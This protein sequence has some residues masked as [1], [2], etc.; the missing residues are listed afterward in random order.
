MA[1]KT[2]LLE[3]KKYRRGVLFFTENFIATNNAKTVN[4]TLERL[5]AS[6]EIARVA[7]GIYTRPKKS[8]LFG[9]VLPSAEEVVQAI[10]KRDKARIVPTG[11]LALNQ[12]GLSTQVPTKLVYLTDG[13]ARS[14]LL[15][16]QTIVLKK[17]TPKNLSAKG[18]ISGLVIQALKAIGKNKIRPEEEN[19]MIRVLQQEKQD[20]LEHDMALAPEW[21]RKIMKKALVK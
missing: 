21:A 5:A 7:L 11:Y 9:F 15:G 4:K 2:I 3:I 17:A 14:I 8:R 10:A 16:K 1:K 20:V 18:T 12:L 13:A 6:G 19:K